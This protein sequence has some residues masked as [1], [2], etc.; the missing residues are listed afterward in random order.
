MKSKGELSELFKQDSKKIHLVIG[1]SEQ[2]GAAICPFESFL[3]LTA[4]FSDSQWKHSERKQYP[5]GVFI[6]S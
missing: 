1:K 3:Q 6:E 2:Y 4:T 5:K